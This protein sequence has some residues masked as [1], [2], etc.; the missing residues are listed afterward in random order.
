MKFSTLSGSE[1]WGATGHIETHYQRI[2]LSQE[3][4]ILIADTIPDDVHSLFFSRLQHSNVLKVLIEQTF[5]SFISYSSP[6]QNLMLKQ[7]Y[8]H[9]YGDFLEV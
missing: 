9:A 4:P 1:K 3:L 7:H 5:I 2:T 6:E 8:M